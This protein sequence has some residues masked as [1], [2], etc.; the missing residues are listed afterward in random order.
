M[1]GYF[2]FIKNSWAL[3]PKGTRKKLFRYI[4][5]LIL[6]TLLDFF[7]VLALGALASIA[8]RLTSND[9]RPTRAETTLQEYL[10]FSLNAVQISGVLLI[11]VAIF[12]SSKSMIMLFINFRMVNILAAEEAG[13][14]TQ[15]YRTMLLSP[16][17]KVES[18]SSGEINFLTLNA[19]SRLVVAVLLPTLNLL[20]DF[21]TIAILSMTAV[22]V[23]PTTTSL[24][25]LFLILIYFI[26]NKIVGRQSSFYGERSKTYTILLNDF[27]N[28][29]V[30][31]LKEVRTY[32]SENSLIDTF[33]VNRKLLAEA[34]QR[35]TIINGVFRYI[36]DISIVL[37]GLLAV[38]LQLLIESDLRRTVTTMVIFLG[39]AFRL[40][41]AIQRIQSTIT[42]IRLS[43]P[44]VLPLIGYETRIAPSQDS[45]LKANE[46]VRW[47][48]N[49]LIEPVSI[50]ARNLSFT[51]DPQS[52]TPNW[53][54]RNLELTVAEG[55]VH[56]IWGASGTGK[57]TLLDILAGLH[58]PSEGT[59][60][61]KSAELQVDKPSIAY[62]A[63]T[64]FLSLGLLSDSLALGRHLNDS[65]LQ[66][67]RFYIRELGL[68]QSLQLI[69]EFVVSE[70]GKNLSGGE[71]QRLSLARALAT[72]SSI[73]FMDEP[74]SALDYQNRNNV[75]GILM[76]QARHRTLVIATHDPLLREIADSVTDLDKSLKGV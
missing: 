37:L 28:S 18:N 39:I 63:Q 27:I 57:T 12:V 52:L 11:F 38:T 66:Q 47:P 62:V 7:G 64:P 22:L 54:F 46:Q 61:F 36:L 30:R 4:P 32:G 15:V 24:I 5:V 51:R 19:S 16:L 26:L 20:S 10:P 48:T 40:I 70:D 74:T 35:A 13:V 8:F 2:D 56:V 45:N 42:S 72:P 33:Y 6:T 67:L 43:R 31:G 21:L 50:V 75:K 76:S 29:S 60:S 58:A 55:A 53:L 73:I 1:R 34:S 3:V 71:K 17:E 23:S 69:N 68:K 49:Q 9:P 44:A 25:F 65:D 59:V 41:P 14:A